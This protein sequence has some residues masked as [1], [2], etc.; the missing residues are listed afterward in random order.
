MQLLAGLL[1][2][3]SGQDA[4]IRTLLYMRARERVIPYGI[5]VAEFTRKLSGLRNKLA[6][7]GSKDEGLIVPKAVGAENRTSSNVLSADPNSVAYSRTPAEILRIICGTN[8]ESLSG[9]IFPIGAGGKIA[10]GFLGN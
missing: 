8:N 1:A 7:C 6:G 9:G 5:T 2:V 10:Q 3:E 4:V